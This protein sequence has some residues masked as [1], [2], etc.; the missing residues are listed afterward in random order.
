[1]SEAIGRAELEERQLPRRP[2]PK[3][4]TGQRGRDDLSE[5]REDR[6]RD[7]KACPQAGIDSQKSVL[8]KTAGMVGVSLEGPVN[9]KAAYGEEY[10]H[11]GK[12]A[13]PPYGG[14]Q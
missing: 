10:G 3:V 13:H 8:E 7:G 14:Q 6:E 2:A 11:A 5:G 12:A 1:M 9:Q 4:R